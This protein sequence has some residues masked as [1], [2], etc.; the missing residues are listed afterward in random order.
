MGK[1]V[2]AQEKKDRMLAMFHRDC[3]VYTNKEVMKAAS[4]EGI[5]SG[6]I[7]GVLKE[8]ICDDL[9]REAKISGSLF[10]W[11]F[12]GETGARKRIE[13]NKAEAEAER[14]RQLIENLKGEAEKLRKAQGQSVDEAAHLK[15]Q[16]ALVV[17]IRGNEASSKAETERLRKAASSNLHMRKKDM[18]ALKEAAN[19]W[20][21]NLFQLRSH[22]INSCGMEP[23]RVDLELNTDKID[24]ID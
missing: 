23:E 6:A 19:R 14:Q 4:K 5:V 2:S 12:P 16:E 1:G 21:D 22:L 20:T 24:Y 17:E 10:Y 15:A 8:L 18:V 9:V 7:E 3:Y 13:L 11:S